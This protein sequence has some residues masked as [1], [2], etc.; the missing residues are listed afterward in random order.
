MFFGQVGLQ[1]YSFLML[2]LYSA[3]YEVHLFFIVFRGKIFRFSPNLQNVG[4]LSVLCEF[5]AFCSFSYLV[6][7]TVT[8]SALQAA[9]VSLVLFLI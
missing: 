3:V 1:K 8:S 2:T 5:N 6:T 9:N 4:C 7:V